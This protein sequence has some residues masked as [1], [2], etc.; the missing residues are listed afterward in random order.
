MPR[1]PKAQ[2][3]PQPRRDPAAIGQPQRPGRMQGSPLQRLEEPGLQ[4]VATAIGTPAARKAAIGGA[5]VS[6]KV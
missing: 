5:W 1:V 6:R 3:R 2:I 4:S